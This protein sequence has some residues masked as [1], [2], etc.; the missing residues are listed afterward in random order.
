[1]K[2][3]VWA[4]INKVY[5]HIDR[6]KDQKRYSEEE[7]RETLD[8]EYGE[9]QYPQWFQQY[10]WI[11]SKKY[12][13]NLKKRK[14]FDQFK[15]LSELVV[16]KSREEIFIPELNKTIYVSLSKTDRDTKETELKK[17]EYSLMWIDDSNNQWQ[18]I[19]D[20]FGEYSTAIPE[21]FNLNNGPYR[22]ASINNGFW[23]CISVEPWKKDN[24]IFKMTKSHKDRKAGAL[25]IKEEENRDVDYYTKY[26]S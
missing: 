7:I 22:T 2:F 13:E 3:R 26:I 23:T 11:M 20:V 1:M 12:F 21:M 18:E 9:Y 4:D 17:N 5:G 10:A 24:R 15:R 19:L 8:W 6:M 16:Y 25:G 14:D